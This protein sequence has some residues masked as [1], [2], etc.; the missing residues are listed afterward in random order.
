M[1]LLKRNCLSYSGFN[2]RNYHRILYS[3]SFL[4]F[5]GLPLLWDNHLFSSVLKLREVRY[6]WNLKIRLYKHQ[7]FTFV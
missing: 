7:G 3:V 5:Q 4:L 1:M 6:V 2:M